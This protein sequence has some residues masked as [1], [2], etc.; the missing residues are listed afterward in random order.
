[1][2]FVIQAVLFAKDRWDQKRARRW[3]KQHKLSPIKRAD[4][5]H[6]V[7]RYRLYPPEPFTGFRVRDRG[8]GV[9]VVEAFLR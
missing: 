8:E 7:L 1:M 2:K 6:E 3:M 9:R 4:A 5:S